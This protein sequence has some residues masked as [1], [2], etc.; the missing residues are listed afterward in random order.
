MSNL[1]MLERLT[2]GTEATETI[3]VGGEEVEIRP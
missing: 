1:E 2:L 3:E